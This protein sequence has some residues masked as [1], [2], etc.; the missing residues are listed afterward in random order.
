MC[1]RD[2]LKVAKKMGVPVRISHSHNRPLGIN[3]KIFVRYYFRFMLKYY[4]T[5]MF[6]CGEEAGDW[7]YGKKNRDKVIDVYKRQ[8]YNITSEIWKSGFFY[9]R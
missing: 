9:Y 7:L 1:I 2:R 8:I 3:P 5:H 4:N 6:A